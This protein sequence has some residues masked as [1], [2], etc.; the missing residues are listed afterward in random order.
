MASEPV[1]E[2]AAGAEHSLARTASGRVFAWGAN[3]SGQLGLGHTRRPDKPTPVDMGGRAATAIA[4]GARFSVAAVA[5][6]DVVCWGAGCD[7]VGTTSRPVRVP[8]PVR[9]GD[10]VE[11]LACGHGHCLALTRQGRVL[12]WGRNANGQ[13]GTEE[14][15]IPLFDGVLN[16]AAAVACGAEHSFV[17]SDL[18]RLWAFGSNLFGQLG[19][20]PDRTARRQPEEVTHFCDV[21]GALVAGVA[22]GGHHTAV[23][24]DDGRV[25]AMGWNEYGQLGVAGASRTDVAAIEDAGQRWLAIG[26]ARKQQEMRLLPALI[27]G[28]EDEVV[29]GVECGRE[30][31]LALA[32]S[33]RVFG[34]GYNGLG[35]LGL[36]SRLDQPVPAAWPA[37]QGPQLAQLGSLL[38]HTDLRAAV[39]RQ[40][41]FLQHQTRQLERQ[42]AELPSMP[43]LR[44]SAKGSGGIA[45]KRRKGS[46]PA[47]HKPHCPACDRPLKKNIH[48]CVHCGH[49]IA[50]HD[51]KPALARSAPGSPVVSVAASSTPESL[52]TIEE[53]DEEEERR[54]AGGGGVLAPT[55][56]P[57]VPEVLV[58]KAEKADAGDKEGKASGSFKSKPASIFAT[59][60]RTSGSGS[61]LPKMSSLQKAMVDMPSPMPLQKPGGREADS[62]D[63]RSSLDT[64]ESAKVVSQRLSERETA[65]VPVV[66]L[67]ARCAQPLHLGDKA[68]GPNGKLYHIKCLK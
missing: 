43:L 40:A 48:F 51:D 26:A 42:R 38:L 55:A 37:G 14:G 54:A 66:K 9:E 39:R 49:K 17:M 10:A 36:G 6:G 24:T 63:R 60:S 47:R 67:C 23:L 32:A 8:L 22:C 29:V 65:S 11:R 3:E 25:F 45:T 31:T 16:R 20:G 64:V 46:V 57:A 13:L 35:Q 5:G 30:H 34:W 7:G 41:L 61:A 52:S 12:V 1:V 62:E 27:A 4:C 50:E 28:L 19:L 59:P 56:H 58:V 2:T 53:E 33:G 44:T 21:E 68:K 15:E 18:G